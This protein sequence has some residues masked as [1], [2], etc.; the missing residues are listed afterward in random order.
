MTTPLA[1][2]FDLQRFVAAQ[3]D[4]YTVALAEL[5]RGSK[6]SH[7]MW[8]IFPQVAGL[9]T[10]EMA[11]RYAI[12]STREATAYL[13]HPLLGQRLQECTGA[14]LAVA[15]KTAEEILGYPDHLKL[16][17]SMTLFAAVS[18]DQSLFH[19]VLQRYFSGVWDERTVEYLR[20]EVGRLDGT[21]GPGT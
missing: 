20:R 7:W 10:S 14:L 17:S 9:G 1:D 5:R 3:Q 18:A 2:P 15:G 13:A 19:Q 11:R 6:R 21:G 12:R 8:F 16:Q 4:T